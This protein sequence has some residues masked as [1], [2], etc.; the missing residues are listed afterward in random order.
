VRVDDDRAQ[1]LRDRLGR[2]QRL[3]RAQVVEL[4]LRDRELGLE[5][6]DPL[7]EILLAL[8]ERRGEAAARVRA[9][10]DEEVAVG[11]V[12]PG[13]DTGAAIGA[14]PDDEQGRSVV[15]GFGRRRVLSRECPPP[16]GLRISRRRSGWRAGRR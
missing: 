10:A 11:A 16:G 8:D 15:V 7:G 13:R 2:E 12:A 4:V 9:A 14:R 3:R 1:L 5:Q 6:L